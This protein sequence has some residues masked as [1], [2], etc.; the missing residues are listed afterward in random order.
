MA[1][2]PVE[3][4][5]RPPARMAALERAEPGPALG[6]QDPWAGHLTR[7]H[8]HFLSCPMGILKGPAV[9]GRMCIHAIPSAGMQGAGL[10]ISRLLWGGRA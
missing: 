4:D 7:L 6:T 9:C 3:R 2:G 8:L 10:H 5:A 1:G